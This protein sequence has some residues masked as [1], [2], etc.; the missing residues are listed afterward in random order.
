MKIKYFE[1]GFNF[2][3]D[4]PGNRLVYH[5]QGCNMLCPWCSNPE[6][7][8]F[9][10]PAPHEEWTDNIVLECKDAEMMF[11]DGGGV[12]LTGGEPT[13]QLRAVRELFEKLKSEGINTALETNGTHRLLPELFDITDFL[14]IDCKHYDNEKH[15]RF[16]GIGNKT[17]LENLALAAASRSQLLIRTPLIGGFNADMA[18]AEKFVELF[19]D[20]QLKSCSFE[21]LKYH[22]YGKVKWKKNSMS[23][24][25]KNAFVSDEVYKHFI[26]TYKNHGLNIIRT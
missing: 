9:S 6:G 12:T 13:M 22:E 18:D 17:I 4:G 8:D 1:K 11:F 16:T 14:I 24:K 23:Y 20:L 7:I 21:L 26:D 3:Q 10:A 15:E 5:L 2:S 25:M 19:N